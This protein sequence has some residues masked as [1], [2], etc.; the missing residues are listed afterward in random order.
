MFG[1]IKCIRAWI[2]LEFS[3]L[4]GT[5]IFKLCVML[6][7]YACVNFKLCLLFMLTCLRLLLC[8]VFY[9]WIL[10]YAK[11]VLC[12]FKILICVFLTHSLHADIPSKMDHYESVFFKVHSFWSVFN[13]EWNRFSF[14]LILF[15]CL[16]NCFN[17]TQSMLPL[18]QTLSLSSPLPLP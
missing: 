9:A 11:Y 18:S 2:F 5:N 13:S 16:F 17:L 7:Y 6:T 15:F 4:L 3:K 1:D 14:S 12:V 10:N 8:L